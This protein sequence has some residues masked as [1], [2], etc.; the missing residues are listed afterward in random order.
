MEAFGVM[1]MT[2][3]RLLFALRAF[4]IATASVGSGG[5]KN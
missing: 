5:C 2:P 3:T 4:L 1:L